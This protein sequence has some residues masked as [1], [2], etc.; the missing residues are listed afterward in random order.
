M[1][2]ERAVKFHELPH[3][4]QRL[5]CSVGEAQV[6]SPRPCNNTILRLYAAKSENGPDAS[7]CATLTRQRNGSPLAARVS[8]HA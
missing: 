1:S 7:I 6:D 2:G 8:L 3:L 5:M 4:P